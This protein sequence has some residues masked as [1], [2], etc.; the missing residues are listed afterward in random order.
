MKNLVLILSFFCVT[1]FNA[2]F[3]QN[4]E[5]YVQD[6]SSM[7]SNNKQLLVIFNIGSND[8]VNPVI[9]VNWGDGSTST[10]PPNLTFAADNSDYYT[11][12]HTYTAMG[13]YS[14]T[15]TFE[16]STSD[17]YTS[18]V[19]DMVVS[20]VTNCGYVYSYI[21]QDTYCG[22][23]WGNYIENAVFDLTGNDNTVTQFTGYLSGVNVT[24]VPYTL[25][26]NDD[27]LAENNL[28]QT[29]ADLVITGFDA[30]GNPLYEG[31]NYMFTVASEEVSITLDLMM[32]YGYSSCFSAAE[33]GYIYF[34]MVDITCSAD[35]D[36]LVTLE[37][38]S[39]MTP[40]TAGLTNASITGNTL[41]YEIHDFNG[42]SWNYIPVTIPGTT[43][44]GLEYTLTVS[45]SDMNSSET[46]ISNNTIDITGMV[47]NSYDPNDKS[48]NQAENLDPG[49]AEELQYTINFQNEG[50][51]D[52][53]KVV[54]RDTISENLDLA[55]FKVIR[56]KHNVVTMVDP[57]TR[58]VTFTFN[59]INLVP[60]ST[61][62][63]GSKGQIVYQV[64]ENANLPVNSEIE[65]TAYIYFDFN[66]AIITNTTYN[67]NTVLS[68]SELNKA[69]F[70]VHPNPANSSVKVSTEVKGNTLRILDLNGKEVIRTKFDNTAAVDISGISNG[71][72]SL[73]LENKNG[74]SIEKLVIQH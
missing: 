38:P 40:V 4:V 7:C 68:V 2:A 24:N 35:A 71:V 19:L 73:M 9:T 33:T 55:S 21:Y 54:V 52:A 62:V 3:S 59:D 43:E 14:V 31:Q 63:E 8:E 28:T 65:N 42:Y 37:L 64:K 72:Y 25:S 36:A 67:K 41:T 49:T 58:V 13:V 47:F 5:M 23:F 12:D 22:M 16:S 20:D 11:F 1:L 26:I 32:Q 66:P 70:S 6:S 56:T 46:I 61:D 39:F 69:A 27:W 60:S 53:L 29:S 50:N 30:Y 34:S 17:I 18:N 48:V 45:V 44:A 57:A 15:V 74:I 51:F 10:L